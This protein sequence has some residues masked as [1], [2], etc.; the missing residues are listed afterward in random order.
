MKDE[1][2]AKVFTKIVKVIDSCV[3]IQQLCYAHKYLEI[4]V[5]NNYVADELAKQIYYDIYL[6]KKNKLMI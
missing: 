6:T 1:P 2:I 4:A 3:T 5:K